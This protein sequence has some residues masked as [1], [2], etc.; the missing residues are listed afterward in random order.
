MGEDKSEWG[1]PRIEPSADHRTSAVT[2]YQIYLAFKEA[3]FN[4]DQAMD[5]TREWMKAAILRGRSK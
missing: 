3:G 4:R 1:L 5:L 2:I